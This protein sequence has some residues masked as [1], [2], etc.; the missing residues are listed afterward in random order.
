MFRHL[1]IFTILMVAMVTNDV[2]AQTVSTDNVDS[3]GASDTIMSTQSTSNTL[4]DNETNIYFTGKL[5]NM[6]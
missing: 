1:R 6:I 4:L 5:D 2:K 3:S